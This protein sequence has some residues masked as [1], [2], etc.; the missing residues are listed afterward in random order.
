MSYYL[1][2]VTSVTNEKL[3]ASPFSCV[4]NILLLLLLLTIV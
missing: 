4:G 2:Q 1:V 3:D